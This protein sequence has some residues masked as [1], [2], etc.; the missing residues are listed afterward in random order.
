MVGSIEGGVRD[1]RVTET[2]GKH[3]VIDPEKCIGC[4]TCAV[5]CA[6]RH[7]DDYD[8]ALSAV[9]VVQFT[10]D[11]VNVPVMCL[12]CDE[13]PCA[14]ACPTKALTRAADGV[15]TL[16]RKRCIGCKFCVQVC[17]TGMAIHSPKYEK[18]LKCDLCGGS[19]L[20]AAWCPCKAIVYTDASP[21]KERRID[22][23]RSFKD[24]A[25]DVVA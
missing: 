1:L 8:M 15:V 13:A 25:R 11:W 19:P 2:M 24:R 12:Q 14:K 21:E 7:F 3:L 23:A 6:K 18:I 5:M 22:T 16:D 9:T 20:C 10:G 17:P 4:R